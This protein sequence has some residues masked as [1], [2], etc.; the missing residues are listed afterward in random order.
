M[1][2]IPAVMEAPEADKCLTK[3]EEAEDTTE[4][5]TPSP[6]GENA[7]ESH[8]ETH[9]GSPGMP[10]SRQATRRGP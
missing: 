3:E 8:T 9:F 6:P 5:K 1:A 7:K 10:I 4:E 2:N